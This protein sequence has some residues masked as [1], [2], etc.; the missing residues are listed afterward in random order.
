MENEAINAG[1][2]SFS[3]MRNMIWP[4]DAPDIRADSSSDG[5]MERNAA[6]IS[7]KAIGE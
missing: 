7:R 3:V 2:T 5:S 4:M 1:Q 6:D